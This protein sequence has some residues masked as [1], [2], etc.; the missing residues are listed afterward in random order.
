MFT[1]HSHSFNTWLIANGI[2]GPKRK[3]KLKGLVEK[4]EVVQGVV[5]KITRSDRNEREFDG[6]SEG[7]GNSR[8]L[9]GEEG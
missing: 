9:T 2:S 4:N 1:S 8:K 3:D 5:E 6:S 7:N